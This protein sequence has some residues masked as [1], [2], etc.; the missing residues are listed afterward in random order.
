MQP[1][2]GRGLEARAHIQ[3]FDSATSVEPHW[4]Y[5]DRVVP[6]TNDA[7]S[8]EYLDVVYESHDRGMIYVGVLWLTFVAVFLA[9]GVIRVVS[10]KKS[11]REGG[12]SKLLRAVGAGTR[13]YTLPESIRP[14]FGRTTRLQVIIL[15]LL[16]GYLLIWNHVGIVYDIWITPVSDMDG[17]YNTRTSLGP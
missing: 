2:T 6:C 10:A 5:A 13:H 12:I 14:I 9:W 1:S 4:G 3:D 11:A 15:G 7:G 16:A 8:C 17:V